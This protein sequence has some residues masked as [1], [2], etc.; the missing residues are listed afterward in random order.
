V[1][2][3]YGSRDE[4]EEAGADYIVKDTDELKKKF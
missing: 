3:G 4:L 2:F 1:L